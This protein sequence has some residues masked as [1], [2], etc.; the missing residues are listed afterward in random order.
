M[1]F[2]DTYTCQFVEKDPKDEDVR[3]AILSHTWDPA[4]EQTHKELKKIQK[5]YVPKHSVSI[6]VLRPPVPLSLGRRQS[7]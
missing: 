5:Q 2:L 4:G 3:Y 1:R 7:G 6:G